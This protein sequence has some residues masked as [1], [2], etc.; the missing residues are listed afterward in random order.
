MLNSVVNGT[1]TERKVQYY[2]SHDTSIVALQGLMGVSS[3]AFRSM[4][5]PGSG[6]ALELHQNQTTNL[7][8]LQVCQLLTLNKPYNLFPT[9]KVI[10]LVNYGWLISVKITKATPIKKMLSQV[11]DKLIATRQVKTGLVE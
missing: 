3:D 10:L 11:E 7:F 5:K 6:L 4:V 1:E 2:S 8:Y 9:E